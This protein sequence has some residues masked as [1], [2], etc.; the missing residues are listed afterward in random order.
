MENDQIQKPEFSGTPNATW[1]KA[2][3]LSLSLH[4]GIFA[5]AEYNQEVI[6]KVKNAGYATYTLARTTRYKVNSVWRSFTE[7]KNLLPSRN[8]NRME[9]YQ[10]DLMKFFLESEFEQG[11]LDKEGLKKARGKAE[12]LI[13]KLNELKAQN[14][15]PLEV[16]QEMIKAQGGY[17][18]RSA[19]VSNILLLRKGNCSARIKFMLALMQ[20]IYPEFKTKIQKHGDHVRALAEINDKWYILE[21]PKPTLLTSQDLE[22]TALLPPETHVKSYFSQTTKAQVFTEGKMVTGPGGAITDEPIQLKTDIKTKLKDYA[23]QESPEEIPEETPETI[24]SARQAQERERFSQQQRQR[25]RYRTFLNRGGYKS[26][27]ILQVELIKSK[28]ENIKE[29]TDPNREF[30]ITAEMVV[31]AKI[32]GEI[33]LSGKNVK[34]LS[35]LRG[36]NLNYVNLDDTQVTDLS[37][38]RGMKLTSLSIVNTPVT[39]LS[40]L[41]GMV[42]KIFRTNDRARDLKHLKK[43]I[44]TLNSPPVRKIFSPFGIAAKATKGEMAKEYAE[45]DRWLQEMNQKIGKLCSNRKGVIPP[46][47]YKVDCKNY[48]LAELPEFVITP[49]MIEKARK[50]GKIDLS[51]KNVKDLSPLKGLALKEVNLKNTAVSNLSP[52]RG[53]PIKMLDISGT[54][55]R[56]FDDVKG[57]PLLI[58][59]FENTRISDIKPLEGMPLNAIAISKYVTDLR[60]LKSTIERG[61]LEDLE[62]IPKG[63]T[64]NKITYQIVR[65]TGQCDQQFEFS[66]MEDIRKRKRF[67]TGSHSNPINLTCLKGIRLKEFYLQ[68]TPQTDIWALKGMPI[69]II[70]LKGTFVDDL[71][72]LIGMPIRRISIKASPVTDLSPL[73]KMPIQWLELGDSATDLRPIRHL[74][75]NPKVTI[76]APEGWTIDRKNCRLFKDGIKEDEREKMD[77]LDR[78]IERHLVRPEER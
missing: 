23:T 59:A 3:V 58:I 45:T 8:R 74:I 25:Q 53:M 34:D 68:A 46:R 16:V 65:D 50:S 44:D 37:P 42:F 14:K 61:K 11:G 4:A 35:P 12:Q 26:K 55:V 17:L 9:A 22:R 54:N 56:T 75:Q 33:D 57:M 21:K 20:K 32:S 27:A 77:P 62:G 49:E 38:L 1:L 43:T 67:S 69:E 29:K 52:L 15:D 41:E 13:D 76:I 40:P 47:G 19:Y 24:A 28:K 6:T 30:K 64:F 66:D 31:R 71:R 7:P 78:R 51:N 5:G 48:K 60:P 36:L 39:D 18:K 10:Q 72:P 70:Y 2:L 63:Y 73:S